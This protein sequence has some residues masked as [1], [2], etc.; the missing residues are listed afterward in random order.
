MKR[1]SSFGLRLPGE[2]FEGAVSETETDQSDIGKFCNQV[3][4]DRLVLGRLHHPS[5][6]TRGVMSRSSSVA[7]RTS[8]V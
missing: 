6:V 8:T 2:K 1:L 4:G 7:A 3:V 5:G